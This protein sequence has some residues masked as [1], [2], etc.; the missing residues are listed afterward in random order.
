[1]HVIPALIAGLGV[2]YDHRMRLRMGMFRLE[3]RRGA[4]GTQSTR[5]MINRIYVYIYIYISFPPI[6]LHFFILHCISIYVFWIHGIYTYQ[7]IHNMNMYT[8]YIICIVILLRMETANELNRFFAALGCRM[9]A[10][11]FSVPLSPADFVGILSPKCKT[12]QW[13]VVWRKEH[14]QFGW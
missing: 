11:P 4:V 5:L 10:P 7:C 6:Y 1:M 8:P 3:V 2:H 9:P 13:S 14:E 12:H